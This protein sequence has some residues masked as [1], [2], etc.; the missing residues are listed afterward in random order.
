[1]LS[2]REL[3]GTF[4]FFFNF[5]LYL[6]DAQIFILLELYSLFCCYFVKV[7]FLLFNRVLFMQSNLKDVVKQKRQKLSHTPGGAFVHSSTSI[8]LL[9]K[10]RLAE[11]IWSNRKLLSVWRGSNFRPYLFFVLCLNRI[12]LKVALWSTS[13]SPALWFQPRL[14]SFFSSTLLVILYFYRP[15]LHWKCH[16]VPFF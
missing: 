13:W 2:V 11:N 7:F 6:F 9:K 16:K 1:M 8:V 3:K 15:L 4:L 5:P 10:K 14:S 12:S